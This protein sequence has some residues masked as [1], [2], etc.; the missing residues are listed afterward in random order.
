MIERLESNQQQDIK[1]REDAIERM[2]NY[3][4]SKSTYRM[5]SWIA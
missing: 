2:K 3:I 5:K 4:V 1:R